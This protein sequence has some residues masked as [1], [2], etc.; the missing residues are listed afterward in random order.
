MKD[1]SNYYDLLDIDRDASVTEIKL[2]IKSIRRK[3][4]ALTESPDR[5]KR[6]LGERIMGDLSDAEKILYDEQLRADYDEQLLNEESY[7]Y[8]D[9]SEEEYE[10][11]E[12]EEY[13]EEPQSYNPNY[14]D[15]EEILRRAEYI[16]WERQRK[17][18]E[19]AR[20]RREE[21]ERRRAEQERA[22]YAAEQRRR[23]EAAKAWHESVVKYR[24]SRDFKNMLHAAQKLTELDPKN[25]LGWEALTEAQLEWGNNG[26]ASM[27]L[28]R[29]R[30]LN[31]KPNDYYD[32]LEGLI[33]GNGG[34]ASRAVDIFS[35]LVQKN[36][37]DTDYVYL[38]IWALRRAG[39]YQVALSEGSKAHN[40]FPND[41]RIAE[42]YGY[43]L[44]AYADA[45]AVSY[46]G[47]L[48]VISSQQLKIYKDT[49]KELLALLHLAP[50]LQENVVNVQRNISIAS[51]RQYFNSIGLL[52]RILGVIGVLCGLTALGSFGPLLRD[53]SLPVLLIS[54]VGFCMYGGITYLIWYFLFPQQW[55]IN[56]WLYNRGRL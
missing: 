8:E 27:A 52:G 53:Q 4:R 43:A 24:Q 13:E 2:A 37:Q 30:Q 29:T 45:N 33:E 55:K 46:N 9:D 40:V 14:D 22:R 47:G 44:T 15:E 26:E 31:P 49:H 35:R 3:Y 1:Y 5:D 11:G 12:D 28:S 32:H 6:T 42:E 18:E 56:R 7:E 36:P 23:A 34:N 19:E 39:N 50:E 41:K 21:Q 10:D 51:R 16:R 20:R 25:L 48:Y 54:L 17:A 38:Y